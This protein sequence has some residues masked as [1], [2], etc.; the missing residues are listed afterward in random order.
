MD[1]IVFPYTRKRKC[2]YGRTDSFPARPSL[3]LSVVNGVSL[4]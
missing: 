2:V 3:V 4:T 1:V